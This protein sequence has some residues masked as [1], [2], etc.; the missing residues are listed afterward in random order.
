MLLIVF[1]LQIDDFLIQLGPT[2]ID[3]GNEVFILTDLG[4][5]LIDDLLLKVNLQFK[6]VTLILEHFLDGNQT[7]LVFLVLILL[8]FVRFARRDV[9][10]FQGAVALHDVTGIV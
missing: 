4:L 5:K 3:F 7:R 6:L 10:V 1:F 8:G 9:L 2:G